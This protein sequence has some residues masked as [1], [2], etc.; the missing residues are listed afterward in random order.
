MATTTPK[1]LPNDI[2]SSFNTSFTALKDSGLITNQLA[3]DTA[4]A[5][6]ELFEDHG[7]LGG[8]SNL[9]MWLVEQKQFSGKSLILWVKKYAPCVT[10][11]AD[12]FTT[13]PKIDKV[14]D[15][16]YKNEHFKECVPA[17]STPDYNF[18][19]EAIIKA[20]AGIVSKNSKDDSVSVNGGQAYL[21]RVANLAKLLQDELDAS[22][23]AEMMDISMDDVKALKLAKAQEAKETVKA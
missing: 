9:Y 14:V 18:T 15:T 11:K 13:I 23:F 19:P 8:L 7:Q 6:M 5:A 12:K 1:T 22:K 17:P 16:A 20:L 21:N 10:H 3:Q 2:W 4:N